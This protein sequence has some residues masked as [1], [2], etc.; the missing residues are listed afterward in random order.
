MTKG[1]L[2]DPANIVLFISA[3]AT[4]YYLTYGIWRCY[5][6]SWNERMSNISYGEWNKNKVFSEIHDFYGNSSLTSEVT[7][8]TAYFNIGSFP[9]GGG[10]YTPGLYAHWMS[11]FG[12]L[13]NPLI[14]FTDSE[15]VLEIFKRLRAKF[16]AE[17][18]KLFL[19]AR[20]KLWAFSLASTIKSIYS[21]PNYPQFKPN[22]INE[23]YSCIMHA[24]FELMNKVIREK[25]MNTR[26]VSWLDIGL[27]RA[28]VYE[29]HIFRIDLPKDFDHTKI[30][31]SG[32]KE[33]DVSLT[34]HD[35]VSNNLVWVGGAMFIGTPDIMYIFTED[36][37]RSV[38]KMIEMKIM[39]TDQQVLY[40]MYLPSFPIKPRIEI[41]LFTSHSGDDWF[42]IGYI[43]KDMHDKKR[44]ESRDLSFY[45][46]HYV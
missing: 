27:F 18:T 15:D 1:Y 4:V 22:T 10:E 26:Y 9:K 21:Q 40:S 12:R 3:V 39:S 8:V 14:M 34:T 38:T 37:I 28:V 42:Y 2:V 6:T 16:P 24:K 13:D 45:N 30:G 46:V 19:I 36:Y 23:K 35:V 41:Q 5:P 7:I 17:R 44:R 32:V 31:Y 25:L 33:F 43:I 11:V 29:T 20:D